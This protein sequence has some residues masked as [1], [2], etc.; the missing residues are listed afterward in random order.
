[1][2]LLPQTKWKEGPER[3]MQKIGAETKRKTTKKKGTSVGDKIAVIVLVVALFVVGFAGYK[4]Y[5]TMMEYKA[6]VD[7]YSEIADTVIHEREADKEHVRELKDVKGQSVKHW[8]PPFDVNF[9]EL[10]SIN[11]D[12]VGWIYMEAIPDIS[13]PIVQG[14]DNDYY[15]HHTYKKESLF[16]GSIFMDMKNS[17]DFSDQNTIIYG[18]NMKNGSMFG[19]LKNYKKQDVYNASPYFWI[20]TPDDAYKYKIFSMYTADV[21]GNTYT[22]IKGPGKETI[23]YGNSMR[24]KSDLDTGIYDF[25]ETNKMI[26]LS[27]CTGNSS[28]RFVVQGVQIQPE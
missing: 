13:Y 16:A 10:K 15:L 28:T 8:V 22:L 6:G 26:T 7:E 2:F 14:E 21:E 3:H 25:K 1:M 12:V 5:S 27:T 23:E 9:D 24:E 17:G 4:L 11:D 18:H 20:I 19:E